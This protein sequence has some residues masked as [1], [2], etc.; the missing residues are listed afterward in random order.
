MNDIIDHLAV[1]CGREFA[2]DGGGREGASR[3]RSATTR[4]G[5]G[6]LAVAGRDRRELA[7]KR[8]PRRK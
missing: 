7:G 3:H 6:V 5:A 8:L 2:G 1:R 4:R